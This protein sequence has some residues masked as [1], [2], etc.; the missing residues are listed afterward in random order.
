MVLCASL[1][2]W[3]T[4]HLLKNISLNHC[5]NFSMPAKRVHLFHSLSWHIS[6][7]AV[8]HALGRCAHWAQV[9]VR[10]NQECG[11]T[12]FCLENTPRFDLPHLYTCVGFVKHF[13]RSEQPPPMVVGACLPI[14]DT[15]FLTR[16]ITHCNVL[17]SGFWEAG[18]ASYFVFLGCCFLTVAQADYWRLISSLFNVHGNM[19][20]ADR[21]LMS[22]CFRPD[23]TT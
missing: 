8:A 19:P 12:F 9:Y 15:W 16:F 3:L 6:L 1:I 18:T 17:A 2:V 7:Q 11:N 4:Q 14:A 10:A 13:H 5:V 21:I 20:P 22:T 23:M